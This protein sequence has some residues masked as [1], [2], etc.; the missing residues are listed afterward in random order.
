MKKFLSVL[1]SLTF[2]FSAGN[3]F[4]DEKTSTQV[5]DALEKES[6]SAYKGDGFG[7]GPNKLWRISP[8]YKQSVVYD[9]N[10]NR[11][12]GE[13]SDQDIIFQ[14]SPSVEISRIGDKF[15]VEAEYEMTYEAFVRDTDQNAFNHNVN[16]KTWYDS[17]R[18]DVKIGERFGTGKT[19]AS[20]EV[21]DRTRVIFNDV[22]SEVIYKLTEKVSVSAL[23]RNYYFEYLDSIVALNSYVQHEFGGRVYYHVT[24][25]TDVYV[26]GS[27]IVTDYYRTS[28]FNSDGYGIY[29][30]ATGRFTSRLVLDVK[31]GFEG[32][33]YER[34]DI[35]SYDNFVGEGGFRYTLTPKTDLILLAKRGIEES[36]FRAVGY[37]EYDK[38]SLG[39]VTKFTE[40]I[41][42]N[43]NAGWQYNRYP[44]ETLEGL[45]QSDLRK[46]KDAL[47]TVDTGLNWQPWRNVNVG[48]KYTFGD[49]DSNL[50]SFDYTFHRTE[51]NASV[52]F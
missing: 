12:P 51:A 33:N 27:A 14:F 28:L 41:S 10:I 48:V 46:R 17:E 15:G 52:K 11:E 18:L 36:V 22:N 3:L 43:Y 5:K 39:G 8:A 44:S 2:L 49:R 25:K 34:N 30:G 42:F 40:R 19:F 31:A 35:N 21:A 32:R 45:P 9:S 24:D 23:Y 29:A 38:I 13:G 50:N 37:Y 4:A 16:L 20:S 26:Q 6:D 1:L 7:V 47:L